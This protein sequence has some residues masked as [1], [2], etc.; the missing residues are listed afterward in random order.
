MKIGEDTKELLIIIPIVVIFSLLSALS[1]DI[2]ITLIMLSAST[3]LFF[4]ALKSKYHLLLKTLSLFVLFH[5]IIFPYLYVVLIKID[6]KAF[7]I[8]TEIQKNELIIA[9]QELSEK[10]QLMI[11]SKGEVVTMQLLDSKS[12]Y[13]DSS[14]NYLN[15]DN[16][17]SID[18]F[19]LH[20]STIYKNMGRPSAGF[21]TLSICDSKG[22]N[23][24]NLTGDNGNKISDDL[25]LKEFLNLQLETI[26]KTNNKLAVD[27][28]K[29]EE[30]DI[31]SYRR[32]LAYSINIFETDNLKPKTKSANIIF[33]IHKF[34]VAIFILGIIGTSFYEFLIEEKRK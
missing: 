33:F 12:A 19:L 25:T 3:F 1:M 18:T 4:F 8:D 7:R 11:L 24:V 6:S 14:F 2:F 10:Y 27:K 26:K 30:K 16:I 20:K 22:I 29:I 21:S 15:N 9:E 5:F 13:L 31:W 32:I 17:L 23:I 28:D 34:L